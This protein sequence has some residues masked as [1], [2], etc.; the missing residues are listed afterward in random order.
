MIKIRTSKVTVTTRFNLRKVTGTRSSRTTGTRNGNS[1]QDWGK[2][3]SEFSFLF[4]FKLYNIAPDLRRPMNPTAT[5][6]HGQKFRETS[7]RSR[8]LSKPNHTLTRASRAQ[9][10][11]CHL[12][13]RV[14]LKL[15]AC[16]NPPLRPIAAVSSVVTYTRKLRRTQRTRTVI[17]N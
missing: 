14:Y 17:G 15:T 3:G 4:S 16:C 8:P 6:P 5:N 13:C 11:N 12:T 7:G 1:L 2:T 9:R 10:T